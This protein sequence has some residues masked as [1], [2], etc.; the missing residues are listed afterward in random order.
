MP[1]TRV[2]KNFA[3]AGFMAGLSLG[4]LLGIFVL[5]PLLSWLS[6]RSD[7]ERAAANEKALYC[8]IWQS[9][10]VEECLKGELK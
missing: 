8:A 1:M 7:V 3:T 9:E 5:V 6:Y 4:I 2:E 10:H